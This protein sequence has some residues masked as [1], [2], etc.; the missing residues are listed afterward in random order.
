MQGGQAY[1]MQCNVH[2]P[3][4]TI[5]QAGKVLA[6]AHHPKKKGLF[7]MPQQMQHIIQKKC[8]RWVRCFSNTLFKHIVRKN[9]ATYS[10]LLFS[11]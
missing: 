3:F 1:G 6:I 11:L 2:A 8:Y 9:I 5:H 10:K 4:M 7:F